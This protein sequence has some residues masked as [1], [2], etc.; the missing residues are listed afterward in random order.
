MGGKKKV[1]D[2]RTKTLSE[3]R[4]GA[5]YETVE[6]HRNV[7]RRGAENHTRHSADFQSSHFCKNIE[8]IVRVGPIHFKTAFDGCNFS[9]QGRIVDSR[10]PA[11]DIV[12]RS[13]R[14]STKYGCG[15]AGV[16]DPHVASAEKK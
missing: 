5:R 14:Q 9:S 2:M 7:E 12:G 16:A 3:Q 4:C 11:D 10:S 1:V 13:A 6:N 8:R 15:A